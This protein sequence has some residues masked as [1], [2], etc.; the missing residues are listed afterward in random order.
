MTYRCDGCGKEMRKGDLRYTVKIDVRAAYDVLEISLTDLVGNHRDEIE[1]LLDDL[2]DKDP[3]EVEESIYKLIEL[4]LCPR[5]QK[6]FIK[7]PLRF[8]PENADLKDSVDMDE[9]LKSLGF[10]EGI[11]DGEGTPGEGNSES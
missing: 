9:F 5:C 4:D 7:S 1:E 10:G 6:A 8:H 2:K 3:K 11:D